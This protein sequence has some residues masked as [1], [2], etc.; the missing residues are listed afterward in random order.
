MNADMIV[1]TVLTGGRPELLAATLESVRQHADGLLDS[2]HVVALNN[3]NDD[4]TAKILTGHADVIDDVLVSD[5]MLHIG[6]ATSLLARAV[7]RA[8]R[9]WWL[10]LEDDWIAHPAG[11]W[12]SDVLAIFETEPRVVQVRLRAAGETVLQ[13]HMV[14]REPV[15]WRDCGG[16][17][18]SPDAHWTNNPAVMLAAHADDAWPAEGER[19]AQRRWW[20][21]GHR[22]SAQ[23]V[24]GVFTHAGE[25]QSLRLVTGSP[26]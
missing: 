22:T 9:I 16:Y 19:A 12:L 3:G 20:N 10:H 14:T 24:P 26:V 13:K 8:G 15:R 11:D 7:R 2:A 6:P 21:A 4:P 1:V 5:R 23:L 25:K 18:I 17:Q